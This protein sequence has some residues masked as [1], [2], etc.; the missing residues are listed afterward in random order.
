[1]L[2]A[3]KQEKF[4]AETLVGN[5]LIYSHVSDDQ[6]DLI[7]KTGQRLLRN[8]GNNIFVALLY[9]LLVIGGPL[10]IFADYDY[11]LLIL[12][13]GLIFLSRVMISFLA[14]QNA[15]WNVLLHPIQMIFLVMSLIHAV[16]A[17]IF[18]KRKK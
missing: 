7:Q 8:F 15:L 9:L 11:R 3:V 13:V 10:F 4:K 1:M 18:Q 17:R 5:H 12:P 14:G 16:F 2:K 6:S